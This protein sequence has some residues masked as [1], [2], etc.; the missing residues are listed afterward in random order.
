VLFGALALVTLALLLPL[1][2]IPSHHVVS[3]Q[4]PRSLAAACRRPAM[5]AGIWLMTLP[6]IASGMVNVLGPLRLHRLGAPAAAIGATFLVGAALSTAVTSYSGRLSDRRGRLVPLRYGLVSAAVTL[7]C[8]TLPHQPAL[9]AVL[10]VAISGSL[11]LFWA[12]SMALISDAAE[13]AGLEQGL[14]AALMNIAWAGGQ[15]IG[16]AGGGTAAS[17]AG[18]RLPTAVVA[19]TCAATLLGLAGVNWTRARRAGVLRA[20][21][22]TRGRLSA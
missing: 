16:A 12:P 4:G 22:E 11:G 13:A 10:I 3:R 18:D 19:A 2:R 14:A 5:V 1:R 20:P 7:L 9:L 21:G 8:F 17:Y 15:V 6:A